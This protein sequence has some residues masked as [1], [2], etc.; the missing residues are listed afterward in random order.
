LKTFLKTIKNEI[1]KK[2]FFWFFPA[3]VS[4]VA[5]MFYLGAVFVA[6]DLFVAEVILVGEVCLES[7]MLFALAA[8]E[9]LLVEDDLVHWTDFLDLVDAIAAARA[10]VR[11]RR[12]EQFAQTLGSSV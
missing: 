12:N 6:V 2:K 3:L 11:Q 9:T 1:L 5:G 7:Q 4:R 10:L 8:L